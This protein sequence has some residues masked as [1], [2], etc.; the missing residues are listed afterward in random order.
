MQQEKTEHIFG[1]FVISIRLEQGDL[2]ENVVKQETQN[3]HRCLG[4]Y[5][6][7]FTDI[8]IITSLKYV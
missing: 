7:Y 5:S 6:L 4:K 2:N 3:L 1:L 8:T